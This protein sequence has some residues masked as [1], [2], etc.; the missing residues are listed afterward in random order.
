MPF[1]WHPASGLMMKIL[2]LR[3]TPWLSNCCRK[4][5][6][7]TGRIQFVERIHTLWGTSAAS[8]SNFVHALLSG[9][10]AHSRVV[11]HLPRLASKA[12]I[13]RRNI[14]PEH[15]ALR[16]VLLIFLYLPARP[17]AVKNYI[18]FALPAQP[19]PSCGFPSLADCLLPVCRLLYDTVTKNGL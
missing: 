8:C 10:I 3:A 2:L 9:D 15:I 12:F 16:L 5:P 1:P 13:D 6:I 19:K 17:L 11:D 14:H 4:S 18:V 7:S